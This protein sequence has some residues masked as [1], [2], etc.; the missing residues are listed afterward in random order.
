M[1]QAQIISFV[2]NTLGC[3]C[4]DE[5]FYSIARESREDPDVVFHVLETNWPE[6]L[7]LVTDVTSLGGRLLILTSTARVKEEVRAVVFLGKDVRDLLEFN[8][9][10]I[11]LKHS[12][13]SDRDVKELLQSA[14]HR[15]HLHSVDP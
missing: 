2:K 9:V 13:L 12:G 4:P 10:R 8:R 11:V 6:I 3:S 1:D 5:V 15:T 14:D 7:P